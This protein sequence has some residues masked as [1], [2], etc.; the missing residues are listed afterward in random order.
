[1]ASRLNGR[2]S[3]ETQ[4]DSDGQGSLVC[5]SS[6]GHKLSDRND[7]ATEQQQ[8]Q[9]KDMRERNGS[10]LHINQESDVTRRLLQ[11]THIDTNNACLEQP[12]NMLYREVHSK[13]LR[14]A[15]N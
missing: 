14:E 15:K 11:G 5:C 12:L 9:Q 2:K 4:G 8:Q 3:E 10:A 7:L 13:T 1:M 6:W